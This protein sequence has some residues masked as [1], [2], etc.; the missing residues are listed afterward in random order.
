MQVVDANI[1][2]VDA[3]SIHRFAG[4]VNIRNQVEMNQLSPTGTRA[5]ESLISMRT[6]KIIVTNAESWLTWAHE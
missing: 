2:Y 1:S 4:V 3:I 5:A 6:E